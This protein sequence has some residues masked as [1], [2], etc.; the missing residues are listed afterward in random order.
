M[1]NRMKTTNDNEHDSTLLAQVEKFDLRG[2]DEDGMVP[3]VTCPGCGYVCHASW[4]R[5]ARCKA[6]LGVAAE[7]FGAGS[8]A[9]VAAELVGWVALGVLVAAGAAMVMVW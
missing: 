3:Y 6:R 9:R 5:C 8:R 7:W 2:A 1:N 4:T